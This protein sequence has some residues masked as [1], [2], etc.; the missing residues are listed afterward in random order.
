MKVV[1][2]NLNIP[3]FEIKITELKLHSLKILQDYLK[4]NAK[5]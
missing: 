3:L 4:T 2:N 1:A 5:K